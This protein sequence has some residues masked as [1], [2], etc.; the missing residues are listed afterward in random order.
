MVSDRVGD[1]HLSTRQG[2][3]LNPAYISPNPPPQYQTGAGP[4]SSRCCGVRVIIRVRI[5]V[6][7]GVGFK[8][9]VLYCWPQS[10]HLDESVAAT[11]VRVRVR[12]FGFGLG[13][14]LG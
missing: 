8:T 12:G 10:F 14:G 2:Q 6:A 5:R 13:L 11:V 4:E 7:V 1:C 3:D 9:D